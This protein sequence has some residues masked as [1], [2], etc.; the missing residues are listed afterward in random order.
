MW[1]RGLFLVALAWTIALG[2]CIS[3]RSRTTRIGSARELVPVG[4]DVYLVDKVDGQVW[5][6]DVSSAKPFCV[7]DD[8]DD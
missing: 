1:R 6:V 7:D 3:V 4:S 8:D 2:G 5:R